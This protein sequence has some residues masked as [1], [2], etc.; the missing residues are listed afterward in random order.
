MPFAYQSGEEIRTGDRI[1]Y[2]GLPGEVEFVVTAP[3]GDPAMDWYL[4]HSSGGGLMLKIPQEFGFLFLPDADED[5]VFVS[6][7]R[8]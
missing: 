4:E 6:R 7:S 1:I 3:I 5:L 8:S 2:A